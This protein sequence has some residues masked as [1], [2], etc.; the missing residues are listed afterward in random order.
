MVE[1]NN[2]LTFHVHGTANT[3]DGFASVV[4]EILTFLESIAGQSPAEIFSIILPGISEIANIHPLLVHFPIA[5][6]FVFFVIDLIGSLMKKE[7]W[8]QLAGGLL[9][10]GTL[11]AGATVVA[12][13][14]AANS[15]EHGE[16]VH[17]IMKRHQ[18][19]GISIL[20]L[21]LILSVWRL[22]GG[23][24]IKGLANTMYLLFAGVLNI[25]II[26][27]ADLGSLMVY[28][29]GVAVKEVKT[30]VTVEDFCYESEH[31]HEHTHSH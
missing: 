2:F 9:Y 27:S 18:F 24:I 20:C 11:A 1:I 19:L 23:G 13:L 26:L 21:S 5:F 8:R 25:L 12:G 4:V 16:N 31:D 7:N 22:L 15:V 30:E 14:M 3:N 10:L 29:Y 17:L 28:K 6:L